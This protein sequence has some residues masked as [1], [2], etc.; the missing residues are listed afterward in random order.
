MDWNYYIFKK[1]FIN[2]YSLVIE[3]KDNK[4]LNFTY[5][6][7]KNDEKKFIKE[8]FSSYFNINNLEKLSTF[9]NEKEDVKRIK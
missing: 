4:V 8:Y 5:G 9:T 7:L 2:Q 3:F 6:F 1:I